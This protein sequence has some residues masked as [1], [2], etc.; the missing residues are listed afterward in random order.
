MVD[1]LIRLRVT[2]RPVNKANFFIAL[3]MRE[4]AVRSYHAVAV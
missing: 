3:S 1:Q 2:T 4:L